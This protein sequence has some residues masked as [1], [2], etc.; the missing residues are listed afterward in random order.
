MIEELLLFSG[1]SSRALEKEWE[2]KEKENQKQS[3]KTTSLK[4]QFLFDK[5]VGK[6][7]H[8][9]QKIYRGGSN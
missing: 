5:R 2:T 8:V 9:S 1:Y 3:G 4:L 7:G 6:Y